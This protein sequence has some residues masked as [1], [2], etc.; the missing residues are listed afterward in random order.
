MS[1][2]DKSI[3]CFENYDPDNFR[4]LHHDDF[5]FY[6]DEII[7]LDQHCETVNGLANEPDFNPLRNA[8][9]VH[10]NH[11]ALE[12][13]W[14]DNGE[15]VTN[16]SLKKDG[17]FITRVFNNRKI[18][19][20]FNLKIT[21]YFLIQRLIEGETKAFKGLDNSIF[22]DN[23]SQD[24]SFGDIFGLNTNINGN[25]NDWNLN[26]E[27]TNNSLDL[28]KLSESSRVKLNIKK[29]IKLDKLYKKSKLG[30]ESSD[31]NLKSNSFLDLYF[32]S[33]YRE[34]ISKGFDGEDEIYFGNSLSV[35]NR[36]FK[37]IK[38]NKI[39]YSFIY[40]FGYFNA[41]TKDKE[42]L[43]DSFRNSFV[44]NFSTEKNL[45]KK[46]GLIK[47]I[48]QNYKYSPEVIN[49]G[50]LWRSS[51]KTGLFLYENHNTQKAISLS[52]GPHLTVGSF[53]NDFFDFT[54]LGATASYIFKEG[55]SIFAFDDINDSARI[56]FDLEQ[57]LYGPLVFNLSSY[58]NLDS[59][60][61]DYGQFSES[62]FGLDLKRR[63]SSIITRP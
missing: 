20:D 15:I 1:L 42:E 12:M 33:S 49:Q 63:A 26:L 22:G 19:G 50:L 56:K 51:F 59:N 27:T 43:T 31:I 39:N 37:T 5:M 28:D 21:P 54:K 36:K 45:W 7:N 60:H 3:A 4:A 6:R 47:S 35:I 52:T 32:A 58:L 40:N 41:K 10:E 25:I 30:I 9:L 16:L 11:Y 55:E 38:G 18:F 53:T 44:A 61:K 62:K 23:I 2:F 8:E 48:N 46:K 34:K 14:E 29:S 13:R 24:N 17:L 57:Q